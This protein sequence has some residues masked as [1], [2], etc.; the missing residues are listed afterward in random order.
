MIFPND[1]YSI[2]L[3][4]NIGSLVG[5]LY[6]RHLYRKNRRN[7]KVVFEPTILIDRANG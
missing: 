5:L 1:I 2:S 6:A 3:G 4:L 7:T